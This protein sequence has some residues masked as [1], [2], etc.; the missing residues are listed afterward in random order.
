MDFLEA[1]VASLRLPFLDFLNPEVDLS[2]ISVL[3]RLRLKPLT[4]IRRWRVLRRAALED[5]LED[6]LRRAWEVFLYFLEVRRPMRFL[7]L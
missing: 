5:F 2:L 7:V 1:L 3:R 4:V 6:F